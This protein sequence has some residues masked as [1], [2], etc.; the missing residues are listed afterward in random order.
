MPAKTAA[1]PRREDRQAYS[2]T[3]LPPGCQTLGEQFWDGHS[4]R[5][6]GSAEPRWPRLSHRHTRFRSTHR[7]IQLLSKMEVSVLPRSKTRQR[8]TSGLRRVPDI[9][10]APQ[11]DWSP[12]HSS[13]LFFFNFKLIEAREKS[14][15]GVTE[16][17]LK[18][19]YTHD[20]FEATVKEMKIYTRWG[21]TELPIPPHRARSSIR[22]LVTIT[23]GEHKIIFKCVQ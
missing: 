18:F 22:Y 23:I 8:V 7:F 20:G 19:S 13:P 14:E 6:R 11:A 17:N 3:G 12:P 9:R 16:K 21:C 10:S 4:A 2:T 1:T 15:I 5:P